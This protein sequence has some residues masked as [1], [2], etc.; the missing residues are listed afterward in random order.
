MVSLKKQVAIHL[1]DLKLKTRPSVKLEQ[2]ELSSEEASKF[3]YNVFIHI[4]KGEFLDAGCGSGML[5]LAGILMGIN[6]IIAVDIDKEALL[7]LK[8]NLSKINK[9]HIIDIIQADFLK[10]NLRRKID[11]VFMNP[12]FGTKYRHMDRKFLEKAFEVSNKIF[13]LHKSGNFKFFLNLAKKYGFKLKLVDA[14]ELMLKQTM[15][16]H[17]KRKYYVS[18]DQ[19]Y[20]INE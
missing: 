5:T 18:V 9:E 1:R 10:F 16:F 8:Y 11:C 7:N 15:K 17:R 2:Y 12:P 3:M 20:F 6:N 13:S 14:F 4:N 19:Y